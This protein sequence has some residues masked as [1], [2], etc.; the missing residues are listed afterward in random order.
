MARLSGDASMLGRIGF[1]IFDVLK[2][3]T[4]AIVLLV[5]IFQ[6]NAFLSIISL[7]ALPAVMNLIK[8]Y[9]Q[10]LRRADERDRI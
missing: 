6:V 10:K 9:T 7:T 2:E 8:K 4:T 3:V 1:L 5:R